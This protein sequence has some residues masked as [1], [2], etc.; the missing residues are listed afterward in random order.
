MNLE[1]LQKMI[2]EKYIS[3]QKHPIEDLYIYNYTQKAQYDK[4]WNEETMSCRGL[5][6][7]GKKEIIARPF[8]K[9]FNY[10]ELQ[11]NLISKDFKVFEKYDGSLGI[12]YWVKCEP[13]IATR[14]SF[15][16]DQAIKACAMIKKYDC[17]GLSRDYTYL[18]EIIYPENRIVVDYGKE[19]KLVL[20]A[21]IDI[22]T[23]NDLELPKNSVFETAKLYD[24]MDIDKIQQLRLED[25]EKEGFVLMWREGFRLKMKHN[26]YVRLHHLVTQVT[27]RS[28]WDLLKNGKP[29]DELLERVPDEFFK[30][31]KEVLKRLQGQYEDIYNSSLVICMNAKEKPTRKDQ[32]LYI[33]SISQ[34]PQVAFALLD[35]KP[36]QP[37]IWKIIYPKHETPFKKEI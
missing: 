26:E 17:S 4:V 33:R 9:F 35:G 18:F 29:I 8:K 3:V 13:F 11:G 14:G 31:V 5:I 21:V 10:E 15:T 23:G 28:I 36:H 27:A 16:S 1:N 25:K 22:K 37:I 32:A 19:E 7:N 34:Y 20:L 24:G 2:Q 30:W 6:M 12:L